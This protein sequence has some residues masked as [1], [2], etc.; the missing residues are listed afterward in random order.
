MPNGIL[1][2][3]ASSTVVQQGD[4]MLRDTSVEKIIL[5]GASGV[6]KTWTAKQLS[7]HAI[8]EGLFEIVL[9]VFCNREYHGTALSDSIARQLSLLPIADEWEAEDSNKGKEEEELE[10]MI[11]KSLEKK[12]VLLILDDE[13][14]KM[15]EGQIMPKLELLL[16][17]PNVS[18]Y[19]VL[20][21]STNAPMGSKEE[22]LV[23]PLSVEESLS[24]FRDRVGRRVYED[25]VIQ[26][27]AET[28][29]KETKYFPAAIMLM[30]KAFSYFVQ[31]DS[32]TQMLKSALKEA[33]ESDGKNYNLAWLLRSGYDLLPRSV[34]IDCCRHGSHFF[35]D[36][37]SIHY[38]EL[39]AYW[40]L[41]G[42]LGHV[43]CMEKAYEK[44]HSVFM[45]LVDCQLLKKLD[46]GYVIMDSD[47]A[48]I[49][50]DEFDRYGF[51]G[52][53]SLG[54]ADLFEDCKGTAS[55]GLAD[56]YE[57]CK[58]EG[59]GRINQADGMIKSVCST[60]TLFLNGNRCLEILDC[61][62][63]LDKLQV[64]AL[65][66]P[67]SKSLTQLLSEMRQLIVL[68]SRPKLRDNA[69]HSFKLVLRGCDFL[70]EMDH[71]FELTRLTVL[72][73]SN[74][75]SLKRIPD[76]FFAH[77]LQLQSLH[78]S[79]LK[80]DPLPSSLYNLKELRWLILRRC[81]SF[82]T[83]HSLKIFKNLMVLD[84]SGAT[85][86]TNFIDKT[87]R[88]T[89]KLQTLNLSH[90][91][92]NRIPKLQNLGQ[93]TH[94]SLRGC[95]LLDRLPKTD[96]LTTLPCIEAL[97][98]LEV[99]D[100][101]GT[102][103]L[104]E[105]EDQFFSHLSSLQI[106]NLSETGIKTLPSI[107]NLCNLRQLLLLGC[108]ALTKIK[109]T[110]FEKMSCL[111][112]LDLS[113][114]GIICLPELS[115]LS[116]LSVLSLKRC[117][118]LKALPPLE[119]LSNLEELNLCGV[120]SLKETGA[121][122]LV[123]MSRLQILDLSE[124]QIEQLPSMSNLKSLRQL[125]IRGC[126]HLQTVPNLEVLMSLQVLDLSGTAVTHIP[127]LENFSNLRE[128]LLRGCSNL[129]GFMHVEMIDLL[130]TTVKE[131]PYGISKL[132]HLE[133]LDLPHT[134]KIQG[135]ESRN[136][137][138]LPEVEDP[139]QWSKSSFDNPH[140]AIS[141]IQFLQILKKNPSSL[142][143]R[144]HLCVHPTKEKNKNGDTY[145]YRNDHIF[146]DI[147]FRTAEFDRF[148]E[149]RS[150][151]IHGFDLFPSG[152]GDVLC[153][154]DCVFFINN[155]FNKWFSDIGVSSLQ[156]IK[157]CWI[158]R[159]T[160]MEGVFQAG[161]EDDIA[162]LGAFKSLNV[163]TLTV[164]LSFQLFSRHPS[165]PKLSTV[166]SSSQLLENLEVLQV[167][168]CDKLETVFE[169]SSPEPELQNLET[170][171]LWELPEL[172]NIG[173]RLPSLQTLK[174]WE[175]PK[176]QKL[177]DTVRLAES[178]QTLW[179]SN[180][181]DLKNIYSGSQQLE[182]LILESCPMLETIVPSLQQPQSPMT[183][184]IKSCNK[185]KPVFGSD[186][187]SESIMQV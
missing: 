68:V 179:I 174:V 105:I 37:G 151:E 35:R 185:L 98:D 156:A 81:S 26:D 72:V 77:M 186:T 75:S 145:S 54:L 78:I 13:G 6:G 97:K 132:T 144:F 52:T 165:C 150:L 149:Q 104:V 50:L 164:V 43:D 30:A 129:E 1:S 47:R 110:S 38:S 65:F 46:S 71:K 162:E 181:V 21:T 182:T 16:N 39:I 124:T 70:V 93:L 66:N 101:S 113:D 184:K 148:K 3:M 80:V 15:K 143:T 152:V 59:F 134:E 64:L 19:K 118:N 139:Y 146:G 153:N 187:L 44:G 56:L 171:Y 87:F 25:P 51:G 17:L 117:T 63:G 94:L 36:R 161:K 178:L 28:F 166:F 4:D 32:G 22:I 130:G 127:S 5:V 183:I 23:K 62:S 116:N 34:L 41:E 102:S 172:T 2:A 11:A 91:S 114:S 108:I 12:K 169:Q 67:T 100:L 29:I 155:T 158:E 33:S 147:L 90:T 20:I 180:V 121:G 176:L 55:L 106:L 112:N 159:C 31:C 57:D 173:C 170:L 92:I 73:I 111:Q 136:M 89:P 83:V 53:T 107:S 138:S 140:I 10:M 115:N 14:N 125:S 142:E 168:F 7:K 131:L 133:C 96:S 79:E 58:W 86:L 126:Q 48:I 95:K 88:H 76:D 42:Y 82:K 49:N 60:K 18:S 9:W 74:A 160:K 45:E 27:L 128:L 120:S 175:C 69:A 109:D 177:E 123:H 122:F 154:A 141:G 103:S 167:R 61:L 85:T 8:K 40:I 24:L 84:V 157:G 137:K 163:Y 119:T 99:L 135:A